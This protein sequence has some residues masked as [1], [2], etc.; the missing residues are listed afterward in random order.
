MKQLTTN[1]FDIKDIAKNLAQSLQKDMDI[2]I[3]H[4]SALNLAS[5]SLGFKNYNT[6]KATSDINSSERVQKTNKPFGSRSL[7]DL[8]NEVKQKQLNQY[9][10]IDS[11]F[12]KFGN[13]SEYS[14]FVY[15]EDDIYFLLFR[16]LNSSTGRIFFNP[17]Y[18]SFSLFVYP[19]VKT[20]FNSYDI[21]I[22]DISDKHLNHK[23]FQITKHLIQS[24]KWIDE[25]LEIMDDLF[26]LME[27]VKRDRNWFQTIIHEHSEKELENIWQSKKL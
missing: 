6:Y 14:I 2:K 3:S 8:A 20:A 18:E 5:R 19:D 16:L 1:V 22:K 4:S 26:T 7:S 17:R 15:E 23:Y 10:P 24:K 11:N 12:I 21:S 13:T 27:S 25:N 9:P